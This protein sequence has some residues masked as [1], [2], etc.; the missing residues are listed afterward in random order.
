MKKQFIS[1]KHQLTGENIDLISDKAKDFLSINGMEHKNIVRLRLS[2]EE[3]LLCWQEGLAADNKTPEISFNIGKRLTRPLIT[4]SVEGDRINPFER[5]SENINDDVSR[6]I[7]AN[8]GLAFQYEYINGI[9][10]VTLMPPKKKKSNLKM[11]LMS[12]VAAILVGG[13]CR[14]LPQSMCIVLAKNILSPFFSMFMGFLSAIAGPM[15]FLCVL[16]GV[17]SIGDITTLGTIGKTMITKFILMTFVTLVI[18]MAISVWFFPISTASGTTSGSGASEIYNIILNIVPKNLVQPF[19][20]GNSLQIIFLAIV[21]GLGI[22]VLDKKVSVITSFVDQMNTLVQ[23]IMGVLGGLIPFFVFISVLS[24]II[25]GAFTKMLSSIKIIAVYIL[26]LAVTLILYIGV[27]SIRKK[28]SPVLLMKKMLPTFLIGL[29]TASSVA[30]FSTEIDTCTKRFGIDERIA[31]FGVPLGNVLYKPGLAI[32]YM[33]LG[34]FMSEIYNIPITAVVLIILA[35]MSTLLAIAT[36]P[37]PGGALTCYTVLFVQLGIPLE[38]LTIAV[39]LDVVADFI[40][41]SAD[42]AYFQIEL[43]EITDQLCM[44]DKKILHKNDK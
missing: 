19:I 14:L 7:L 34:L 33:L 23:F 43:I 25:S 8:M 40:I 9:N 3:V 38:A 26:C 30:A 41:T 12:I 22:L 27:L 15:I 39:A 5:E 28:I 11:M 42:L 18:S 4:L 20:K 32:Y 16:W 1:E 35:I 10:R 29:T 24:M 31:I 6:N 13:L 44:L 21:F 2:V 17:Y 36:P 37:V